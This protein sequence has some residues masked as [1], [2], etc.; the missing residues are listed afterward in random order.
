MQKEVVDTAAY[1]KICTAF[2]KQRT[3]LTAADICAKTALPLNTV[4]DLV[5]VAADEFSAHLQVTESGEIL[6]TFPNTWTSKYTGFKAR[7]RRA[8][9][10]L[11]GG[12]KIA[13]AALFKVWIMVMLIGYFVFF[14]LLA[15]AGLILSM[16]ARSSSNSSSND[17][18][19]G[20]FFIANLF[21]IF[22]R[23]WFYSEL[24]KPGRYDS[25]YG[26][27]PYHNQRKQK[28]KPLHKAIFSFVF[29]DGDPNAGIE[30][31][32]KKAI[33]AYLQAHKGVISLAEFMTLTGSNAK[34]AEGKITEFCVQYGGMPEATEDG[35]VVYCFDDLLKSADKKDRSFGMVS[36]PLKQLRKFSANKGNMNTAFCFINGINLLFG[37]YFLYFSLASNIANAAGVFLYKVAYILMNQLA[38]IADPSSILLIGL[39]IVPLAFSFLFWIIPALRYAFVLE[40]NETIKTDNLRKAAFTHIIDHPL[41]VKSSD[42]KV[43]AVQCTPAALASAQDKIIKEIGSVYV[44]EVSIDQNG[45]AVYSFNELE[46]EKQALNKYRGTVKTSSTDLGNVI[47]E[48]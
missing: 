23:L 26:N 7:L 10:K 4:K 12:I 38:G 37:S 44:P 28:G 29:G 14:L 34:T 39:G 36:A 25:Y 24:T 41:A 6:Y 16:A 40:D 2:K 20:G 9:D 18:G 8:T 27:D 15:L 48:A 13:A 45:E 32:E 19:G 31:Q 11:L 3:G 30:E 47:F 21:E 5:P 43:D 1:K 22:I 33:I 35:T 46:R 17:S 42:L